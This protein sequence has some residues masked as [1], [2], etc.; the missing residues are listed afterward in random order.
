FT[1]FLTFF[2]KIKNF[3]P[4]RLLDWGFVFA[5]TNR[6]QSVI[7]W[8]CKKPQT[9]IHLRGFAMRMQAKIGLK[10]SHFFDL[11]ADSGGL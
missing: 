10:S 8:F 3:T 4:S 9:I 5:L 7:G 6:L 1:L 11:V 2:S